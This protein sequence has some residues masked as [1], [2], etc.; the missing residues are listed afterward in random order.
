MNTENGIVAP[1]TQSA[2]VVSECDT[3]TKIPAV[4]GGN[5]ADT[6]LGK[7]SYIYL[8]VKRIFDVVCAATGLIVLSPVFSLWQF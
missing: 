2:N 3:Q 7:P 6:I 1:E 5:M 8:A 4:S